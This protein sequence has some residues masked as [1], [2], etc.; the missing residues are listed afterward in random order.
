MS[1]LYNLFGSIYLIPDGVEDCYMYI[2]NCSFN[3][4]ARMAVEAT[5][6]LEKRKIPHKEP[7]QPM[8]EYVEAMINN[9]EQAHIKRM[10]ELTE[11]LKEK[12]NKERGKE[13][14]DQEEQPKKPKL[15]RVMQ[16]HIAFVLSELRNSSILHP[17]QVWPWNSF[18]FVS[19]TSVMAE[20]AGEAIRAANN[21]R[22]GKGD[23]MA[24]YKE[25]AQTAAMC[26]RIMDQI[27]EYSVYGDTGH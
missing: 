4:R 15:K 25:L 11:Y 13:E 3:E 14:Q 12:L 8:K 20:E 27:K 6:E 21:M 2:C 26:L 19:Q 16:E 18:N 9:D 10:K 1:K 24:L 22:E 17:N 5:K 7:S 23:Q